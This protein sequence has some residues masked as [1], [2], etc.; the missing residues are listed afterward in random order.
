[1]P[2]EWARHDRCW[3]AWPCREELWGERM[4][5][6]RQAYAEV[7]QAIAQCEP[8]TMIA[9][10][11]LT[12][13]ASLHCGQGISV[14]P[15]DYDDSWIRDTG[16]SFVCHPQRGLVGIEWVGDVLYSTNFGGADIGRLDLGGGSA[17]YPVLP[18][19]SG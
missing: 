8:V 5:A 16:P 12:A 9:R 3:M 10:P 17:T 18:W 6:A 2:A 13:D 4:A 11:D 15:L 1:M 7:A 19:V 14:L